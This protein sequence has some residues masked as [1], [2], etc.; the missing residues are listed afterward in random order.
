MFDME[1]F[2]S[3]SPGLTIPFVRLKVKP[4]ILLRS[5]ASRI[6]LLLK[7]LISYSDFLQLGQ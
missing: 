3:G 4:M 2:G 1:G 6:N 5:A 7:V